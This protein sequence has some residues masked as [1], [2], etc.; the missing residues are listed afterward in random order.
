IRPSGRFSLEARTQV[1]IGGD[2][3]EIQAVEER[4]NVQ[5]G[6]TDDDRQPSTA[7][8]VREGRARL[9]L[10]SRDVVPLD[11]VGDVDEMVWYSRALQRRE[12]LARVHDGDLLGSELAVA[13]VLERAH[14]RIGL[15][16]YRTVRRRTA[17][18]LRRRLV[19]RA[20]AGTVSLREAEET[21]VQKTDRGHRRA[22]VDR[23]TAADA[24]AR[25]QSAERIHQAHAHRA[26]ALERDPFGQ[27]EPALA[28]HAIEKHDRDEHGDR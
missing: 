4:A 18:V 10:I 22:I 6:T 7:R 12:R 24:P 11:G 27:L 26:L 17:R 20:P 3:I 25:T 16:P 1:R 13:H 15:A 21:P 5:S 9:A 8:D 23:R 28:Q 2:G 19:T 14:D